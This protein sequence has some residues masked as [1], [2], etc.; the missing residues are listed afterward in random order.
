[1]TEGK[2]PV[3]LL[4]D[5]EPDPFLVNRADPEPWRGYE[6]TQPYLSALRSELERST[7][8]PVRYTWCFRMDPQIAESYGSA[9][10][11]MERYPH[12]IE[13]AR[14]CGDGLG[15]HP[16]AYRWIEAEQ[17]W[18]ED[19]GS[20]DWVNT[21][22]ESSLEAFHAAFGERC[23]T[24]RFG[25][26]WINTET[27][28]RLERLGVRYD[29]TVEPGLPSRKRGT[30]E[31]GQ[32]TGR[33]PDYCRVPRE[34]YE[35]RRDDVLKRA[36]PGSRTIRMVPLTSAWLRLGWNP[37]RQLR[38]L[39]DNGLRYRRQHERLSMWKPWS[40][41]NG[42]QDMVDRAIAAQKRPYL[43]FAIRSSIGTGKSYRH[44]DHCLRTL[45]DHPQ[46]HRFV[47]STPAQALTALAAPN[48]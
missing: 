39:L 14:R 45:V 41:P 6:M 8:A 11:A 32:S 24:F 43:C 26:F 31:K 35:P 38:R 19:L 13:E 3:I 22:V 17:R 1:M 36:A 28:N 12:F 5:V 10:Y 25:N 42:F 30:L 47:F 15:T 21:C 37:K 46:S 7:Q 48:P 4:V 33:R 40:A 44:V 2:I 9:T 16:H 27:V 23:E 29:L 20:Q 34:P 18:V